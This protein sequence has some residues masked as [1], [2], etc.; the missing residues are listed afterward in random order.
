MF[1]KMNPFILNGYISDEYFCDRAQESK[2]ITEE[3]TSGNNIALLSTRRMGKTGLILHCFN[4]KD[5]KKY[6]YT[7][8]VD[9]YPTKSLRDFVFIFSK[10]IFEQLKPFGKKAIEEFWTVVKSLQTGISFDISGNPNIYLGLGDIQYPENTLDE[11]FRYISKSSKPCLIAIDEF[12]QIANYPEKNMEA[13]LRSHIQQNKNASFIFAGSRRH[14]ISNMFLNAA[15]P[16]YQSVSMMHLGSIDKNE[17]IRFAQ[18]HFADRKKSITENTISKIYDD[19]EGITWYMQKILHTLF[20]MT[21]ENEICDIENISYAVDYII[22]SNAFSYSEMLF[23]LPEKQKEL[24]IATAKEGKVKNITSSNFV[25]KYRLKSASSVQAALK[26][27]LDKD[28]LTQEKD[29]IFLYDR[30]LQKWLKDNY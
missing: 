26:G 15:R 5:I 30:F 2:K 3:L 11:I 21:S 7:F 10:V 25:G 20:A 22:Q 18:K 14:S 24:L 23:R 6:Y 13:L 16:F 17:Y 4:N 28:F 1:E 27:L 29:E 19:F 9:I 8:F 12:Q